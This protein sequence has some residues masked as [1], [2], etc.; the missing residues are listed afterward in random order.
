VQTK[1]ERA[2]LVFGV[3]LTLEN[4]EGLLKP[5]M[6]ADAKIDTNGP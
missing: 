4:Q 6:P 2:K 1:Q 3:R 5:G